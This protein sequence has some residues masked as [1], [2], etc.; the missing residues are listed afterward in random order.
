MNEQKKWCS[1]ALLETFLT[2]LLFSYCQATKQTTV[3][4]THSTLP[5]F[6]ASAHTIPSIRNAFPTQCPLVTMH[7]LLLFMRL[8][9]TVLF[10]DLKQSCFPTNPYCTQWVP[11]RGLSNILR[12]LRQSFSSYCVTLRKPISLLWA[13]VSNQNRCVRWLFQ[14]CHPVTWLLWGSGRTIHRRAPSGAFAS[15]EHVPSS[16]AWKSASQILQVNWL[17]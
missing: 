10:L 16:Q 14:S 4:Q 15:W 11:F 3:S 17:A 7:I 6:G 12:L 9:L 1:P 8:F 2:T 13:S 5:S